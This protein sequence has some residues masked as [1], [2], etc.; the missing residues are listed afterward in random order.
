LVNYLA[1]TPKCEVL[2]LPQQIRVSIG[3]AIVLGLLEGKL[4]AEPSTVYLMT[5][6][7]GKCTANCGFCPQASN[8]LSKV[9]LLSRVS[10]P[11]FSSKSVLKKIENATE[12]GRI[13]R[14]CIQAL[15]YPDVFSH[16]FALVTAIKQQST[17]PVSVSCQPLNGE[18]TRLLV[19]GGVDRIGIA[20]DAVTEK[21]FSEVKGSIA[22]GPYNWENQFKQLREAVSIFGKGNVSTHLIVGLGETEKEVAYTLQKCVDLSVLPA[23]FAFTPI[24][25]TALE[26]KSQP[27]RASYR[28]VQLARYLIVNGAARFSDM[29]FDAYGKITDFGMEKEKLERIVETGKPFLTSGCPDCNRPFYNEKPSGPIY[30]YPRNIRREEILAIKQQLSLE[31]TF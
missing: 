31:T 28:R 9:E 8:S 22:G 17:I 19:E 29:Q 24:R 1:K 7:N 6:K 15:N 16:L 26:S 14:V 25:G 3:S 4:D 10:W 13:R 23:L 21:L 12:H 27:P 5:Y 20:L 18:N 30:N 2:D 11:A